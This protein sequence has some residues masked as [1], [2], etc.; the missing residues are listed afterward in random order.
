VVLRPAGLYGAGEGPLLRHL[1][2]GDAICPA[3]PPRWTNRL[4]RQD[5]ARAIVHLLSLAEPAPLYLGV[6]AQPADQAALLRELAAMCGLPPPPVR[7]LPSAGVNR[8]CNGQ[9]LV[10]SGFRLLYPSWRDGYGALLKE[11]L[12]PDDTTG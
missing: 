5:A 6:D 2:H 1:R 9:R 4:H 10:A 7:E 8:R 12:S 3:G 11:A